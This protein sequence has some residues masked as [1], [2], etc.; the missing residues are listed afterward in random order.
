M[1]PYQILS[2]FGTDLKKNQAGAKSVQKVLTTRRRRLEVC[3]RKLVRVLLKLV[4]SGG[5]ENFPARFCTFANF[6]KNVLEYQD[7][8]KFTRR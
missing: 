1:P 3:R 7:R 8:S 4:T 6:K 5:R 2:K